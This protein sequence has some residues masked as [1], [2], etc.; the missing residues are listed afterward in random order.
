MSMK[1]YIGDVFNIH[2]GGYVGVA[3][4][5]TRNLVG[6]G[7]ITTET[8]LDL[9]SEDLQDFDGDDYLNRLDGGVHFGVEFVGTKGFGVGSRAYVG[10]ADITNDKHDFLGSGK[11]RTSEVSVYAIIR[12]GR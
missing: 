7:L 9:F 1:F 10:L 5:G 12:I 6:D 11:A 2:F 8:K 4:A 3:V